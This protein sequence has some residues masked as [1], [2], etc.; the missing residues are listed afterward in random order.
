MKK[1]KSPYVHQREKLKKALTIKRDI[2]WTAKQK[3]I[4]NCILDKDTKCVF[5]KGLA[6]TAKTF[7]AM[8]CA[9]ELLNTHKVSDIILVRSA[10][11]SAENK[12]GYLPGD[13]SEK[14]DV[15]LTPFHDKLSELLPKSEIADLQKDQRLVICPINYAR[16]SHWA[17]K[18]VVCDEAQNLTINEFKTLLTRIGQFTKIIITGDPDQSDLQNGKRGDFN[19]VVAQF[20]SADANANGVFTFEVTEDDIVRSEFIKYILKTFQLIK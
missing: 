2:P 4:I 15:Y 11:E 1:D 6:G 16:G 14:M 10:V 8:Y 20:N 12:L 19:K 7:T 5:I 18:V 13:I 9:L 17:A 3:D